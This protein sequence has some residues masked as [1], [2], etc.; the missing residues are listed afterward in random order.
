MLQNGFYQPTPQDRPTLERLDKDGDGKVSFAEYVEYY[1]GA[2]AMVF[3]S[4]CWKRKRFAS[5][6]K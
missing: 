1:R 4:Q 3:R 2:T 5:S 6:W